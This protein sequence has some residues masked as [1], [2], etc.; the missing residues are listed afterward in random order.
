VR[1]HGHYGGGDGSASHPPPKYQVDIAICSTGWLFLGPV[2]QLFHRF[3][4][5]HVMLIS[6]FARATRSVLPSC[7]ALPLC[8]LSV[9]LTKPTRPAPLLPRAS[10]NLSPTSAPRVFQYLQRSLATS[11]P[12]TPPGVNA[13]L[14]PNLQQSTASPSSGFMRSSVFWGDTKPGLQ[15]SC[16]FC[17]SFSSSLGR[18][19]AAHAVVG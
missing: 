4:A 6:R 10:L 13:N 16:L 2:T 17:I 8:L 9:S 18:H 19:A 11:S 3:S 7:S 15:L 1:C 14:S 12:S 5:A